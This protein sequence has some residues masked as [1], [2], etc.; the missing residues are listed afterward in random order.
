[1]SDLLDA[2]QKRDLLFGAKSATRDQWSKQGQAFQKAGW[3]Y[4][5]IDFLTQ[6]QD[7]AGLESLR[8]KAIAEGDVFLFLKTSR[9]LGESGAFNELLRRCAEKAE[10]AGKTRYAIKGFEKIGDEAAVQRLQALIANDGDSL[11]AQEA[12]VFIPSSEED[13]EDEENDEESGNS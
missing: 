7:K 13:L 3:D 4:D 10:S 5:A 2:I 1:M 9:Y 6:A 8:D 12:Q 11:A